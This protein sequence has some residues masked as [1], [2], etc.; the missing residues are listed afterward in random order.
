MLDLNLVFDFP[1]IA[2]ATQSNS[3]E[4]SKT[5]AQDLLNLYEGNN[6]IV[7]QIFD[8]TYIKTTAEYLEG[9][10]YLCTLVGNCI[11]VENPKKQPTIEDSWHQD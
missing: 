6:R 8:T 3:A 2:R 1:L 4:D 11:F 9:L 7:L 5:L 10:G